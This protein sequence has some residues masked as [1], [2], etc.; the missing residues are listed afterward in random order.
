M[1]MVFFID[2]SDKL[3]KWQKCCPPFS[4]SYDFIDRAE[5]KEAE[6]EG[7]DRRGK[8]TTDRLLE[9]PAKETKR[10]IRGKSLS[11]GGAETAAGSGTRLEWVTN[12]N[13]VP[14]QTGQNEE[15]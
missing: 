6:T 8:K 10:R 5:D 3:I 4:L 9:W 2:F 14:E 15:S 13:L 12:Q 1:L 11:D 7:K